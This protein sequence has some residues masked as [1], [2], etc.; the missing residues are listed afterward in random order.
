M[1]GADSLLSAF[2]FNGLQQGLGSFL[3]RLGQ[4]CKGGREK[5]RVGREGV[6]GCCREDYRESLYN[7]GREIKAVHT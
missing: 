4:V 2:H 1:A 6:W 5:V 7:L 3:H